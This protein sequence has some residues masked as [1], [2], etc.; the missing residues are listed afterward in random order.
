MFAD[1]ILCEMEKLESK[2]NR[3]LLTF[4]GWL[5]LH[6]SRGMFKKM[7]GF[8]SWLLVQFLALAYWL[9]ME[10]GTENVLLNNAFNSMKRE[11]HPWLQN[12]YFFL[13]KI[14]LKEV[15][16]VPHVWSKR[17]LKIVCNTNTYLQK[18]HNYVFREE[19]NSKCFISRICHSDHLSHLKLTFVKNVK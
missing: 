7:F 2:S 4:M 15:W 9:R 8:N 16:L 18:H 6:N 14:R 19:N 13:F 1:K 3:K 10:E 5:C 12:V 11:N 17:S